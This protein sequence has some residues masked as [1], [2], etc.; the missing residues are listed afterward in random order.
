MP[1]VAA[2]RPH[3]YDHSFVQITGRKRSFL[4]ILKTIVDGLVY[5]TRKHLKSVG[6][7]QSALLQRLLSFGRI[8]ADLHSI[9]VVTKTSGGN[10]QIA[11]FTHTGR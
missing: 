3:D 2:L 9:Y 8:K 10:P 1:S 5:R 7:I 6:K 4:V 11:T